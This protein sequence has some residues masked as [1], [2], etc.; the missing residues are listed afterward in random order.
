[1]RAL[2]Q[3]SSDSAAEIRSLIVNSNTSVS[4]GVKLVSEMGGA[5]EK[6]RSEIVGVTSQVQ[7]IAVGASEQSTGLAE[8]NSGIAMLDE[9]TQ[10]NAAMV[11]ESAAAARTLLDKAATLKGLVSRF[12]GLSEQILPDPVHAGQPDR[13]RDRPGTADG[14]EEQKPGPVAKAAPPA[15]IATAGG[16]D[17]WEDF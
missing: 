17:M 15:R 14:W 16:H 6:I 8:I 13:R 1:M 11:G 7:D 4:N 2:A 9:V 10:Q 3:R 5:I 12:E